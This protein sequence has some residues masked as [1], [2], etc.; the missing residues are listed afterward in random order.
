MRSTQ[1]FFGLAVMA[2][3]LSGG[4]AF[5]QGA[6]AGKKQPAQ[7]NTQAVQPTLP[8]QLDVEE[9]NDNPQRFAGKTISVAGEVE[10]WVSARSFV[11]E[12]GGVFDDEMTVIVPAGAK[13]IA[14][15][16]LSE[17][18]NIVVTGRVV[19]APLLDIQRDYGWDLY[20]EYETEYVGNRTYMVADRLDYQR[21]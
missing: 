19:T 14:P 16:F 7:G 2:V 10:D 1:R 11:L 5:A 9:V 4:A 18:A 13:G 3:M 17:D 8:A 21:R 6:Q 12:S 20:P 15:E